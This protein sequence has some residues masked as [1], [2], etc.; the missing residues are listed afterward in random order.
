MMRVTSKVPE[1]FERHSSEYEP[2]S[3]S[4]AR[5]STSALVQKHPILAPPLEHLFSGEP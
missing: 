1:S 3:R 5:A 4:T 2:S